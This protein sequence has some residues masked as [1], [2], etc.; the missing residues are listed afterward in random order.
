VL[1]ADDHAP[2]RDKVRQ[3]L[4]KRGIRVC[5][6]ASNAVEAVQLALETKPD[7]CLLEVRMPGGG[8]AAAWEI[9]ARVPTTKIV[10]LTVSDADVDFFSALRAGAVGYLVKDIDLCRLPRALRDAAE[11]TPAISPA[12]IGRM[13]TQFRTKEPRFRTTDV[14]TDH[15]RRLT[16]R[17][18]DVLAALAEGLPTSAIARRLQ[19]TPSGVRCNVSHLLHKLGLAS[20]DEAVSFFR[21]TSDS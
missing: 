9:A 14:A 16:S 1:I 2:T 20:R 8:V 13:L 12:L 21:E 6:E 17:E 19:L 11:G 4:R 10:M 15:G 3:S 18:W 5:A 7:I